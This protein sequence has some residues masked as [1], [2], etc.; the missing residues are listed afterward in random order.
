MK[1]KV[2]ECSLPGVKIESAK[3]TQKREKQHN[4]F[5][6]RAPFTKISTLHYPVHPV[7][8]QNNP[9]TRIKGSGFREELYARKYGLHKQ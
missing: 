1:F 5:Q 2:K 4:Q 6:S 3:N 7:L 9:Q 8:L